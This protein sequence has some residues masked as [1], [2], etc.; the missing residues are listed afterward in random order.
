MFAQHDRI[1]P[2][3]LIPLRGLLEVFPGGFNGI[4]DLGAR[5]EA[6]SGLLAALSAGV[7]PNPNVVVEDRAVPGPQDAP[8]VAVRIYRPANASGTLA[9]L[10]Y[11]HG[12]GMVLGNLDAE[13][14]NATALCEALGVVVVSTDYRKAP[15]HPHPAQVSDCYAALQWVGANAAE[16]GIDPDRLAIYG[17][18]AGGNLCLATAMM[19][20]DNGG[21]ALCFIMPIYPMV[22]HRHVT[23]SSQEITEV[24]IW[25]RDGNIEAWTHFLGDDE[26][27]DYAAPLHAASLAGLPPTFIDV[28]TMDLFRDEDIALVQRLVQ[29]G[30]PTEFH[31]NPGA[32]HASEL[33]AP[34]AALSQRIVATRLAALTR[35]LA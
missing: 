31:L 22:D 28:G 16:L 6:V 8:D 19:A 13:H 32:Y 4:A 3:S 35:A 12:G 23:Q 11:I 14:L 17:S 27:D 20:R 33:F 5:R 1:D 34:E 9:G 25:D 21:P 15:E 29:E 18:S 30:V 2:E 10:L 7:P 26:P 24:G